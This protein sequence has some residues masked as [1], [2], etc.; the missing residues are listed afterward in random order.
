M[1]PSQSPPTT[2]G[3]NPRYL[4]A[5]IEISLSTSSR[6]PVDSIQRFQFP[7]IRLHLKSC[8]P[9][10]HRR[11]QSSAW[12]CFDAPEQGLRERNRQK[13]K[14]ASLALPPSIAG[15]LLLGSNS[16][17]LFRDLDFRC[18]TGDPVRQ[19]AGETLVTVT[20][21]CPFT[22]LQRPSRY[23]SSGQR[24]RSR[25]LARW[26]GTHIKSTRHHQQMTKPILLTL[27]CNCFQI[28]TKKSFQAAFRSCETELVVLLQPQRR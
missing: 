25:I 14:T 13:T 1:L 3:T 24:T 27:T 26:N 4:A 19:K 7:S 6:G 8:D 12:S 5:S 16:L 22:A 9:N 2:N 15:L 10:T 28:R 21:L 20:E 23:F 18:C 17:S 11:L